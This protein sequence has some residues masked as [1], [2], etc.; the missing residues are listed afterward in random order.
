MTSIFALA[1][2]LAVALAAQGGVILDRVAATVNGDVVTLTELVERAGEEYRHAETLP[3][4][5]RDAARRKALRRAFDDVVSEKLMAGQAV[6]LGLEPTDA[7]VDAAIA[8]IKT[9]NGLDEKR[10]DEA[11]AQQG[12][13]RESFRRQVKGNLLTY[14]LLGYKVRSRVKVSEEDL[15]AY[16]QKNAA[17]FAGQEEVHVRHIFLPLAEGAPAAEVEKVRAQGEKVLQRLAAGEDFA[18]VAREV[19]KGPG[20]QEGG[21]LGWL[22]RGVVQKSLEDAAFGLKVNQ[23]SSLV[24]AGPGLHVLKL[25]E[26]RVAG[27]KSF[28][29]ARDTIRER[30]TNEQ[31]DGYK[32]QYLDELR[33]DA[34]VDVKL[35][36]LKD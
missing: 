28:D 10:L 2:P 1:A 19:S 29:E 4:A 14:N 36:E 3:A 11:L 9:R 33:R 17:E 13:D 31:L 34:L 8:D 18:A 15:R 24:R 32:Q 7:Q 25:E 5:E 22:R 30:L 26:R 35:P 16:Y 23:V 21:D 12:L 27:G 20:A 6:E